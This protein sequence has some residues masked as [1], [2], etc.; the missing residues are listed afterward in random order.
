MD[1]TGTTTNNE[2]LN[3][4]DS[5]V[6]IDSDIEEINIIENEKVVIH[7]YFPKESWEE[8]NTQLNYNSN[9]IIINGTNT[10]VSSNITDEELN[11]NYIDSDSEIYETTSDYTTN[12]EN[13]KDSDEDILDETYSDEDILD[14][15]YSDEDILDETYSDEDILD[16]NSSD[17]TSSDEDILDETSSDETKSNINSIKSEKCL[18]S[19]KKKFNMLNDN[20]CIICFD[21]MLP[22]NKLMLPCKHLFHEDCILEWAFAEEKTWH[23]C[24]ICRQKFKFTNKYYRMHGINSAGEVYKRHNNIPLDDLSMGYTISFNSSIRNRRRISRTSRIIHR[25]HSQTFGRQNISVSRDLTTN[26]TTAN[27]G[28]CIIS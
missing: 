11:D 22:Q 12:E 1:I 14:E 21:K 5:D 27:S 7:N 18:N 4:Y 9:E 15:T 23:T 17:E 2:C 13:S 28:C 8:N 24:P 25:R 3:N 26:Y 6:I 19:K 20:D 10:D 16:E